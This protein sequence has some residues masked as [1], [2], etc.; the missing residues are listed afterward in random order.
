MC[1][2]LVSDLQSYILL[3]MECKISG[4]ARDFGYSVVRGLFIGRYTAS[5]L[6]FLGF[7]YLVFRHEVL[8]TFWYI[9]VCWQSD[10]NA[11]ILYLGDCINYLWEDCPSNIPISSGLSRFCLKISNTDQ[12]AIGIGKITTFT[13]FCDDVLF[14]SNSDNTYSARIP[15]RV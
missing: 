15:H 9:N 1:K 3:Q 11:N 10:R 5:I 14:S 13:S 7:W 8:N 6:F 12:N 4:P 2:T